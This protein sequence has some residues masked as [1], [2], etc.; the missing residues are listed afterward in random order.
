[1]KNS[2]EGINSRGNEEER[3]SKLEDRMVDITA[4]EPKK[5]E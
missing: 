4:I 2:L 1:M 5:G 3:V